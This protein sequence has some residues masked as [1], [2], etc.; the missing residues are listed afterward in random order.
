MTSLIVKIM[1][2]NFA[3]PG[4]GKFVVCKYDGEL[5]YSAELFW[6]YF[7]FRI[8][9]LVPARTFGSELHICFELFLLPNWIY[10]SN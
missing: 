1:G 9:F 5:I 3:Q 7:W 8:G 6:N 4:E 2:Q 10:V